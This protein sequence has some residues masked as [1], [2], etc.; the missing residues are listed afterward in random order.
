MKVALVLFALFTFAYANVYNV[1]VQ[2]GS[3]R[4]DKV[5]NATLNVVV[6]GAR[7]H[8]NK[9]ISRDHFKIKRG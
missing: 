5:A 6:I 9:T 8:H 7:R 4:F 2:L 1:T 3:Q